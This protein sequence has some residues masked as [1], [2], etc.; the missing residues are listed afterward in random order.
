MKIWVKGRDRGTNE[1]L[2]AFVADRVVSNVSRISQKSRS[3]AIS[4]Q[5][6]NG[7]R[8]GIDHMIRVIVRLTSGGSVVVRQR[9]SNVHAGA[10]QAIARAVQ[11]AKRKLGRR[12]STRRDA[13]RRNFVEQTLIKE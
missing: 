8:G 7:P 1:A 3:I 12:R 5:D 4:I 13:Y 2:R 9:A 10:L 6:V 11:A